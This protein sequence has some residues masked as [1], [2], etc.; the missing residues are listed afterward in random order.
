MPYLS[1]RNSS[2]FAAPVNVANSTPWITEHGSGGSS[3]DH[4][5]TGLLVT[6]N[7]WSRV[8]VDLDPVHQPETPVLTQAVCEMD[9]GP[10]ASDSDMPGVLE[11]PSRTQAAFGSADGEDDVVDVD[12]EPSNRSMTILGQPHGRASPSAA[13]SSSLLGSA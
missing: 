8:L 12:T 11:V 3:S 9:G 7:S 1:A 13:L 10:A 5:A 4:P 2:F 6:S